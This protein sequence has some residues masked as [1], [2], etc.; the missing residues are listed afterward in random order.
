MLNMITIS[1]SIRVCV[2]HPNQKSSPMSCVF[3]YVSPK[4]DD[5]L[6]NYSIIFTHK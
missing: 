6:R 1:K 5:N 3:M 2:A 4:E